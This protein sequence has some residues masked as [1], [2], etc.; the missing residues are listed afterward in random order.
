MSSLAWRRIVAPVTSLGVDGE[1]RAWDY[2]AWL[3][4]ALLWVTAGGVLALVVYKIFSAF[5]MTW[6]ALAYHLP[7]SGRLAGLCS[8]DCY[9][10]APGLEVRFQAFPKAIHYLQAGVWS[11]A[12][13][14]Q[15]TALINVGSLL[16]LCG[17]LRVV[18]RVSLPLAFLAFLTIPLVLIHATSYYIDLPTNVAGTIAILLLLTLLIEPEA[19]GT[20]RLVGFFTAC[21]VFA[22]AKP[23]MIVPAVLFGGAGVLLLAIRTRGYRF[24]LANGLL[25]PRTIL[26]ICVAG[27]ALIVLNP[28]LNTLWFGNPV[29]P[30]RMTIGSFT[31]PGVEPYVQTV[32]I[33]HG[34]EQVP[35]PVRW[36][37][38]VFEV[39]A[40][41]YREVPWTIDQG[42]VTQDRLSFRMGGYGVFFV[43][44]NI[45]FL[46]AN[47]AS[48]ALRSRR[49]AYAVGVFAGT[50]LVAAFLPLSHELR[51]YMFWMLLLVSLNL[52][53]LH[54][55]VAGTRD[56]SPVWLYAAGTLVI[57]LS[58]NLISGG[59]YLLVP[60]RQSVESIVR[61]TGIA[62]QVAREVKDGDTV[63]LKNTMPLSYLYAP[64]FHA[65]RSYS[66]IEEGTV[67]CS[68]TLGR[69]GAS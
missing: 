29:Y 9:S 21:A 42:N 65:G 22:N 52:L 13:L 35:S 6:D 68:V 49:A 34:L 25:S 51:Y 60:A 43:L 66:V 7:F 58:V 3:I 48:Q 64:I 23:Q 56:S 62:A 67:G 1:Q 14:P 57:L 36:L 30:I 20:S 45:L 41:G 33:S 12:G 61:D 63:C 17:F 26:V 32:S 24:P 55:R 46:I 2:G 16:L 19:F 44:F 40:Y 15:A 11:L 28:V 10:M 54:E 5:D 37:M 8:V 69:P 50:T 31:L 38:S 4:A 59:R 47:V 39:N 27:F 18:F 53:L